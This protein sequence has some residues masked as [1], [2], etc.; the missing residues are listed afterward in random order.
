MYLKQNNDYHD[1]ENTVRYSSKINLFEAYLYI[2][3]AQD[4][5]T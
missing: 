3:G 2:T 4:K 5:K 1:K